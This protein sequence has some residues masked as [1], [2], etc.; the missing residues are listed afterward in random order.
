MTRKLRI[1]GAGAAMPAMTR[2]KMLPAE[3]RARIADACRGATLEDGRSFVKT[4]F[5]IEI[6]WNS[7]LSVWLAWQAKQNE[8]D[9]QNQFAEQVREWLKDY[10]PRITPDELRRAEL[11]ALAR[12]ADKAGDNK[13]LLQTLIEQGRD[14][15]RRLD[16][17]K[18]EETKRLNSAAKEVAANEALTPEEKARRMKE[19]FG[20]KT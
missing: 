12:R 5:G 10:D 11:V 9:S 4:E 18:F 13:L 1:P 2:L 14:E 19:I 6:K 3:D 16:R 7:K 15:E 8:F 20:I 17:E